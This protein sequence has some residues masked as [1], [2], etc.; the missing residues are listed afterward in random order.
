[1]QRGA[2]DEYILVLL[3][4]AALSGMAVGLYEQHAYVL[5]LF[6]PV[7][8]LVS[9]LALRNS[10]FLA[11]ASGTYGC[12][13]VGQ[14]AYLAAAFLVCMDTASVGVHTIR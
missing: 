12:I 13:A 1:M 9:A 8:A 2:S 6:I 7:I 3:A 14:I 4:I 11:G 10:G 5:A